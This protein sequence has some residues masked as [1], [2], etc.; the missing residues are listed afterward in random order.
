VKLTWV[1]KWRVPEFMPVER[2][3]ANTDVSSGDI[4]NALD[5]RQLGLELIRLRVAA[6]CRLEDGSRIAALRHEELGGVVGQLIL[7]RQIY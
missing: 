1:L 4:P 3:R 2:S 7:Q 5:K 6:I